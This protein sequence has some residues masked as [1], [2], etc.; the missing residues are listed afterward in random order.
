[1][2]IFSLKFHMLRTVILIAAA[3]MLMQCSVAK[4]TIKAV[5]KLD[6]TEQSATLPLNTSVAVLLTLPAEGDYD[7]SLAAPTVLCAFASATKE[8]GVPPAKKMVFT[9]H[10]TGT[11]DLRFQL[12]RTGS[13]T[14]E[15]EKTLHLTIE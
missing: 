13:T 4:K 1:M 12:K 14:V 10:T 2:D 5:I 8:S 6:S 15:E 3:S 11:E 7:W 9:L